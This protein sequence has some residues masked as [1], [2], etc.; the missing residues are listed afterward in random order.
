MVWGAAVTCRAD[1][2]AWY[3]VFVVVNSF[4]LVLLALSPCGDG[5][6]RQMSLRPACLE[7]LYGGLFRPMAVTRRQF[8]DLTSTAWFDDY[9]AG[10]SVILENVTPIGDRLSILL[11]GR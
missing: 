8:V 4:Q 11:T 7:D 5:I 6:G 2:I 9:A 10:T 3:S 1:V